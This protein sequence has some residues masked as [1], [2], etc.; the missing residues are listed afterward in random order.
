MKPV[1][2]FQDGKLVKDG[3]TICTV[4]GS[5]WSVNTV[6]SR[7]Y[8]SGFE[9]TISTVAPYVVS[10]DWLRKHHVL[11]D[12]WVEDKAYGSF[13]YHSCERLIATITEDEDGYFEW[14]AYAAQHQMPFIFDRCHKTFEEAQQA[15]ENWLATQGLI[16]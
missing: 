2:R 5:H 11:R 15:A 12:C 1:L 14:Q 3:I 9:G 16:N 8:A 10:V 13:C 7:S 6:D 4:L